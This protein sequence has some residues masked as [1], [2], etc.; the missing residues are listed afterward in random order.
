MAGNTEFPRVETGRGLVIRSQEAAETELAR[1]LAAIRDRNKEGL[2]DSRLFHNEAET[3]TTALAQFRGISARQVLVELEPDIAAREGKYLISSRPSADEVTA[4]WAEATSPASREA[5]SRL[6]GPS[7]ED[8]ADPDDTNEEGSMMNDPVPIGQLHDLLL[9][10]ELRLELCIVG[11]SVSEDGKALRFRLDPGR[12]YARHGYIRG[13]DGGFTI[14]LLQ[15]YLPGDN[16]DE[17]TGVHG[18]VF[19]DVPDEVRAASARAYDL[20]RDRPHWRETCPEQTPEWTKRQPGLTPADTIRAAETAQERARDTYQASYVTV[21]PDGLI[22]SNNPPS[23][24]SFLS[25]TPP[26]PW[27]LHTG[28]HTYPID[29]TP[30]ASAFFSMQEKTSLPT[31]RFPHPTSIRGGDGTRLSAIDLATLHHTPATYHGPG[32]HRLKPPGNGKTP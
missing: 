22:C 6:G 10:G 2:G 20:T 12:A 17:I 13:V 31:I 18:V 14:G 28:P 3:L 9:P 19:R 5:I 21:T 4:E 32:E 15:R 24:K 11:V 1:I 27:S 8:P 25:V 26:G 29:G 7:P 16:P 23:V 30:D